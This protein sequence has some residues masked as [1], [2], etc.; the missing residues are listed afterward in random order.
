MLD[1]M[2]SCE[3]LL[4]F[5]KSCEILWIYETQQISV[6]IWWTSGGFQIMQILFRFTTDFICRF[7]CGLHYG[8]HCEFYGF[9]MKSTW[10][11]M[12]DQ[13]KVKNLTWIS[14]SYWFQ[15]DFMWNLPDF[16]KSTR[17]HVI[18]CEIHQISWRKTTCQ[19]W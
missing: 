7:Q 19:E 15:V 13:E 3:T 5:M 4:N 18:S 6:Q 1:F 17:F 12:K 2:K 14:Y 16:M 9:H 10:F 8:F 11:H